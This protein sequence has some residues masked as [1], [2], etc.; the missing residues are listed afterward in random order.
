LR[1]RIPHH[2]I[3]IV[4]P[5]VNFT[6]ADF[7]REAVQIIADIQ[8]RGKRVFLVG[9]TGLYIRALLQGLAESPGGDEAYRKDLQALAREKGN[10]ELLKLL[11]L[12]DPVT[13]QRLHQNDQVRIIRALEV[14]RQ[15][16]RPLSS[17]REEHGFAGAFYPFLKIGLRVE[18]DELY[19]RIEQRVDRMVAA[20]L[21]D[22]VRGL[23]AAGYGPGLKSMRSIGY[24]E[25]CAFLGGACDLEEAIRLIKRDSR[26][27][28]KRQ[29]T[30]FAREKEINWLEYPDNFATINKYV[31]EFLA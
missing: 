13:A 17:F 25:I 9:G 29:L 12:V 22:E 16:G 18:R 23:L 6:A 4:T 28:A 8:R 31:I 27:Y 7:R 24:K 30:W 15:S 10:A 14:Y 5:D 2:L 11:T 19:R 20:G 26:R 21:V 1:Q 3:D